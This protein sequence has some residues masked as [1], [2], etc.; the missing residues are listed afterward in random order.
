MNDADEMRSGAKA[1]TDYLE[2]KKPTLSED[3]IKHIEFTGIT[4]GTGVFKNFLLS[5]ALDPDSLT[6]WRNYGVSEVAYS[7]ELDASVKLLPL[8]GRKGD[9]HPNPPAGYYD[10]GTDTDQQGNEFPIEPDPDTIYCMGGEW[11][12]VSYISGSG[13]PKI[14]KEFESILRTY[15]KKRTGVLWIPAFMLSNSP[16]DFF[17]DDGFRD[18]RE[19][20]SVYWVNPWWKFVH[21]RPSR[22]G[23]V[24]Y[25]ELTGPGTSTKDH[26]TEPSELP[27]RAITIGPNAPADSDE[28]L[29]NLLEISGYPSVEVKKSR[30]PYR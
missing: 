27:I 14:E 6:L 25:V 9:R 5:A 16:L 22:F 26:A 18:E 13:D 2:A 19:I 23:V 3:E 10:R 4:N 11:R 28:A 24:P 21:F 15:R 30:T 7:I 29:K 12:K 8:E 1:F 20:R 17:K